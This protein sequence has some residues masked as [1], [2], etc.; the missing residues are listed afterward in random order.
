MKRVALC[1]FAK[2]PRAGH[3]KT[4]L[5]KSIGDA[6][7]LALAEAF[8]EDTMTLALS[9]PDV[10]VVVAFDAEP[11]AGRFR[12]G[13]HHVLQGEG[14]LGMRMERVLRDAL[15][16]HDVAIALGTDSPSVPAAFL[17][18][19]IARLERVST[20]TAALGATP[21]GGYWIFG[22]TNIREGLLRGVRWSAR[23]TL[24][25]TE[26]AL[27]DAAFEILHVDPWF[28][29]DEEG[30]LEALRESL[31]ADLGAAPETRRVMSALTLPRDSDG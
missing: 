9:V 28:D 7:A 1:I 3:V 10:S 4:R 29:V 13:I 5:A 15:V 19:A 6:A 22:A 16:D 24:A 21:D 23:E 17:A 20:P 2:L 26:R 12:S 30:D 18:R 25:D 8:L 14:D 11:P 27:R 31:A